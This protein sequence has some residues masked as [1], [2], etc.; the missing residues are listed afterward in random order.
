MLKHNGEKPQMIR[1]ACVPLNK[2]SNC[3]IKNIGSCLIVSEIIDPSSSILPK[4]TGRN[5]LGFQTR[6]LSQP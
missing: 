6:S 1:H 3:M 4:L 2:K 5:S